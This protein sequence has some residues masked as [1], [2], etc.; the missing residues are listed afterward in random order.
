MKKI[1]LLFVVMLTVLT[2]ASAQSGRLQSLTN[3]WKGLSQQQMTLNNPMLSSPNRVMPIV[4][5]EPIT[6]APAGTVMS[7][8]IRKGFSYYYDY[9]GGYVNGGYNDSFVGEYIMGDDGCIYIKEA[10]ASMSLGSYLKL[11]KIDDENYVAHTAQLI[12]V[13]NTG[14]TPYPVFATRLVYHQYSENSMGFVLDTD[15]DGNTMADIYFTLKDGVLKQKDQSIEVLNGIEYPHELL[16]FTNS[17]GGWIGYGDG[18]MEFVPAEFVPTTLPDGAEVKT[19][20]FVYNLLSS[21]SGKNC[22]D[23]RLI[24]YAEVGDDYYLASPMEGQDTWIK[25]HIDRAQGTVTFDTQYLGI[26]DGTYLWFVPATY[27]DWFDLWDEEEGY[28]VWERDYALA[29][30]YVCK[31]VN[32]SIISDEEDKQTF[33][34]SRSDNELHLAG[35]Y[36]NIVVRPYEGKPGIPVDPFIVKYDGFNGLFAGI[37][38]SMPPIDADKYYLDVN[39]LYFNVYTKRGEG[40]FEFSTVDYWAIPENMIDVPATYIDEYDFSINKSFHTTYFYENFPYVGVQALYKDGDN[41]Y[42]SAIVWSDGC[43]PGDVDGDGLVN[44]SD[45]TELIDLLLT[46]NTS[47]N[48][49]ADVDFDGSVNISDVTELIDMLL[50]GY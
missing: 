18:C 30:S 44:I 37:T 12:F 9:N 24:Q 48:V 14:Y 7:N 32:G 21:R 26:S 45:V 43:I 38:F 23:A 34:I 39:K 35:A 40:P 2:T 17:D 36:S 6:E 16:G 47:G 3:G 22:C 46:G 20:G 31:Y 10:C 4:T 42:R 8:Q 25:G 33:A 41:V 27:N 11:D 5:D 50:R 19:G 28:G 15:E 49:N 29:E 1:I 13:D